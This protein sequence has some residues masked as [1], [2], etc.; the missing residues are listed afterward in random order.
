MPYINVSLFP[1]NSSEKKSQI[2]RKITE[3]IE[4]ELPKVPKQ[5]IWVT[6]TEIPADEWS[7]GGEMCA[8]S[9]K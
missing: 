8:K 1:G 3:V 5:N 4:E 2:A 6:F 7:I 9:E